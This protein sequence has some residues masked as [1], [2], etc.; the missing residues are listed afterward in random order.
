MDVRRSLLLPDYPG[1]EAGGEPGAAAEGQRESGAPGDDGLLG[2]GRRDV[3]G[4]ERGLGV[5]VAAAPAA[6]Q[7]GLPAVVGLL[8]RAG[9]HRRRRPQARRGPLLQEQIQP[10]SQ[11]PAP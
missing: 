1:F 4:C 8:R 7:R 6:V 5:D 10:E 11:R 2:G 9:L 3:G